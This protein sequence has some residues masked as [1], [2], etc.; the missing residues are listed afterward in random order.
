MTRKSG[1]LQGEVVS[2][3]LGQQVT[4]ISGHLGYSG[5]PC[6]SLGPTEGPSP[7]AAPVSQPLPPILLSPLPLCSQ[8]L[9]LPQGLTH[10]SFLSL[11]IPVFLSSL[12]LPPTPTPANTFPTF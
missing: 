6:P 4:P 5:S 9:A 2:A 3:G 10:D 7:S 12:E 11:P 1:F 8:T